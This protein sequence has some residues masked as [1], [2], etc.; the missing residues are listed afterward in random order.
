MAILQLHSDDPN[1]GYIIKKNPNSSMQIRSIRKGTAFTWY[2]HNGTDFNIYFKDADN[3]VSFGSQEFDYLNISKYNSPM[4]I[5]NAISE[6]FSST[7]REESEL[8]I[9]SSKYFY[10]NLLEIKRIKQL[11]DF[12]KYFPDFEIEI[13]EQVG[14]NYTIKVIT[15]NSWFMLLNYINLMMIF[16]ALSSN[17]YVHLDSS[18]IE[19]YLNAMNRLDAPFFIRY[20]VSRNLIKSKNQFKK[21]KQLLE[22]SKRY[23]I[24]MAYGNTA[25]QRKDKI[26]RLLSFDKSILD[27]GCGEG[28]YAI[29][30]SKKI[31][32]YSYNAIDINP[33]LLESIKIKA[34]KKEIT[35]INLFNSLEDF[36]KIY[37]DELVDII[38]TEVIEHMPKDESKRLIE[39]VLMSINFNTFIITV[40]NK[41]FNIFYEL[42]DEMRHDDHDW[43]PTFDEFKNFI[44]NFNNDGLS[45]E[46]IEIGDTIDGISTSIGCIIKKV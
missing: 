41:D 35:N 20:L 36:I 42:G 6:F 23:N 18:N 11:M 28:F 38:L 37:N 8:D 39:T 10:I 5:I 3:D 15:E 13:T 33:N 21:Y 2:S 43:E 46:F 7:V 19:K 12:K 27:I 17:D 25:M 24:N 31:E 45:F 22:K 26:E 32:K 29:D 4:F 16:I 14:K 44:A 30:F 34:S 9:K 1:F 40:P